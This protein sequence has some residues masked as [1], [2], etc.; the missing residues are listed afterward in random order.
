MDIHPPEHPIRSLRDFGM[1]I[2]TVTCGIIIALG[3][4]SAMQSRHDRALA[5]SAREEFRAEITENRHNIEAQIQ[6]SAPVLEWMK[7]TMNAA[8]A[9]LA[10]KAYKL[11]PL[12]LSRGFPRLPQTAW[13]TALATQAI[14]HLRFDEVRAISNVYSKQTAVNDVIARARDQWIML[15]SYGDDADLEAAPDATIRKGLGDLSVAYSYATTIVDSEQ[16]LL[17]T[18]LKALAAMNPK[19]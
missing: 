13:D 2:L 8:T 16:R 17:D 9:R 18:Y 1:A 14:A 3:L 10:H 12:G 4:E 19:E 7:D 11:T 5:D 6:A 15:A